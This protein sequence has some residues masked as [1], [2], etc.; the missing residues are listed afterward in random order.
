[1]CLQEKSSPRRR[2]KPQE[3]QREFF[4]L[5]AQLINVFKLIIQKQKVLAA[6]QA[7]STSNKQQQTIT[8][9]YLFLAI[10]ITVYPPT[11]PIS[12][13]TLYY[14]LSIIH[15]HYPLAT[16]PYLLPLI[17]PP[18]SLRKSARK[19]RNLLGLGLLSLLSSSGGGC[20]LLLWGS[21]TFSFVCTESF[22][23]IF[24]VI[25]FLHRATPC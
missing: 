23:H 10:L 21:A 7:A 14:P 20:L 6:S 11:H 19:P 13:L 25:I 4:K 22:K 15:T 24:I 3:I 12:T 9:M 8:I 18:S 16:P 17:Y 1:M 2:K 5:R